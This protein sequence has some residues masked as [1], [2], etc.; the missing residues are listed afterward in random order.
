MDDLFFSINAPIPV[1]STTIKPSM[2]AAKP[3]SLMVI[4][5]NIGGYIT[6]NV[7]S[8]GRLASLSPELLPLHQLATAWMNLSGGY[9]LPWAGW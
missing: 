7:A 8:P 3:V 6:L 1:T 4:S 5:Q 2:L 9:G